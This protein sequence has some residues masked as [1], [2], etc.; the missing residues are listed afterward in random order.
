MAVQISWWI[1]IVPV[2]DDLV[3]DNASR[4]VSQRLRA[5]IQAHNR[6][7]KRTGGVRIVACRL[8]IKSPWLNPIEPC[9]IHGKRSILKPDRKLTAAE[10]TER[11]CECYECE[12]FEHLTQKV[13]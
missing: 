2:G 8:P 6:Q 9:W 13:A 5:C 7:A 12:H 4:H 11:G 1:E 10:V 3:W